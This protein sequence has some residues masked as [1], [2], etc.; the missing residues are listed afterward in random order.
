M[1][2]GAIVDAM[3]RKGNRP[4]NTHRCT[5]P[6]CA[7]L[8]LLVMLLAAA[9]RLVATEPVVPPSSA[10]ATGKLN[11][12]GKAVKRLVLLKIVG[13]ENDPANTPIFQESPRS[14]ENPEHPANQVILERPG[15]T[16]LLPLGKYMLTGAELDGGFQ[17]IVP[18]IYFDIDTGAPRA[19]IWERTEFIVRPD[20]PCSIKIGTPFRP[21][22]T[23]TRRDSNLLLEY[24]LTDAGGHTY[25]CSAWDKRPAALVDGKIVSGQQMF[26]SHTS[27]KTPRFTISHSGQEI[28]TCHCDFGHT[29][30]FWHSWRV[31]LSVLDGPLSIVASFDLGAYGPSETEPIQVEWHWYSHFWPQG[32]GWILILVLLMLVKENRSWQAWT[33]LILFY[34]FSEVLVPWFGRSNEMSREVIAFLQGSLVAW[35][36]A[37]LLGPW[38]T[39]CRRPIGF[40]LVLGQALIV[41]MAVHYWFEKSLLNEPFQLLY[42]ATMFFPLPTAFALSGYCCQKKFRPVRFMLWLMLWTIIGFAVGC[43]ICC[44]GAFIWEE[45]IR[46]KE[47]TEILFY[48]IVG[49]LVYAIAAYL[50]NLPYMFL[51]FFCP[52]YR[53]RFHK[54]LR[55][56]ECL[57]PAPTLPEIV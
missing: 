47:F 49:P 26:A 25:F 33:I 22:V 21:T 10:P 3:R 31:P 57:P 27:E 5:S 29:G 12:E 4:M 28:A 42:F 23:A 48:L 11:I 51:A 8:A 41:G 34:C 24:R 38:L 36:A 7:C 44:L 16:V 35:T 55:L 9:G 6:S 18:S 20:K 30:N 17:C 37:W 43:I 52:P 56:P 54:I 1:A 50:V 39:K 32:A 19:R 45:N 40:M 2:G 53:E 14:I 13:D 15:S 46:R